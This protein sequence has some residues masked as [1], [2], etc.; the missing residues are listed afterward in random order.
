MPVPP[1][2]R[3]SVEMLLEAYA[4]G[5]F[6]MMHEDGLLYWHDPDPRAVFDLGSLQPNT[7]QQRFYRNN[8]YGVTM[9]KAF[10]TVIKAC[11]D[12]E[13][14]W[15]NEEMIQAYVEMNQLGHAL[16][17]ETWERGELIGGIYG[18]SL[19]RAFFGES[20]FSRKTNASKA[21]FF[22]LAEYLRTEG[23]SIFDTQ[24]LNDHT[25]SLGAT[26]IQRSVF[27]SQLKKALKGTS[28]EKLNDWADLAGS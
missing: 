8:G 14:A 12:R 19:G 18:V 28:F 9:N 26:E 5:R 4:S 25:A 20:M 27:R 7:R 17:V 23:F 16:S 15:I 24:Y 2:P 1:Q 22:H 13:P 10:E 21:A 6:P 11:A 3:L